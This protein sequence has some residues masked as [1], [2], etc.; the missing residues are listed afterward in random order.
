MQLSSLETLL[1]TNTEVWGAREQTQN[2][3]QEDK[4]NP[5]NSLNPWPPGQH[6][7]RIH[8]KQI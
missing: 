3:D 8:R 2:A 7:W 4:K 6:R 5:K 1:V